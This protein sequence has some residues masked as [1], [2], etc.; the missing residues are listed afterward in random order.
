MP[1]LISTI[2]RFP[3]FP[4]EFDPKKINWMAYFGQWHR[5]IWCQAKLCVK[6]LWQLEQSRHPLVICVFRTQN[7]GHKHTLPDGKG[8]EPWF[9][10][11]VLLLTTFSM[12]I[13]TACIWSFSLSS[14]SI[15]SP[16]SAV[17]LS[18][19]FQL[20]LRDVSNLLEYHPEAP[21]RHDATTACHQVEEVP[22][23]ATPEGPKSFP[24][25]QWQVR[26]FVNYVAVSIRFLL[27]FDSDDRFNRDYAMGAARRLRTYC[28]WILQTT[29]GAQ[30]PRW[31]GTE[32]DLLRPSLR[33]MGFCACSD[34]LLD[35]VGR[36][37]LGRTQHG[38]SII[39][40]ALCFPG[41][42]FSSPSLF[43]LIPSCRPSARRH[44][45]NTTSI[46]MSTTNAGREGGTK[47]CGI[48]GIYGQ[49]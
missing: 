29:L 5:P 31:R 18:L 13:P 27:Q 10:I 47:A 26:E 32:R 30:S 36:F 38:A 23:Q 8:L 49:I 1:H 16:S 4:F 33:R 45:E 25:N 34:C 2:S 14:C 39:L 37:N 3:A 17:D 15:R 9:R 40:F 24:D 42:G 43:L 21:W 22:L 12:E 41:L 11:K 7:L 6:S 44:C 19:W 35:V 46:Q 28:A 20:L 48:Y